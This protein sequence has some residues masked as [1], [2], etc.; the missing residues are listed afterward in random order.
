MQSVESYL[1]A[2][3]EQITPLPPAQLPLEQC[4]G[5]TLAENITAR[6]AVPRFDN[7][8]MDGFALRVADLAEASPTSPVTLPVSGD[9]A[10]GD[11]AAPLEPGTCQRI[12]TGA[13]IP[14][15]ADA[16]V[17]VE[18]TNIPAGPVALPTEVVFQKPAKLGANIR[19]AAEDVAVGATVL[20]AGTVLNANTLASAAS[21]G[22]GKL[23]VRPRVRVAVVVSGEELVAP[24]AI[25][26]P[27]QIPD[28]N[29]ILVSGLVA[30]AGGELVGT[31]RTGDNPAEFPAIF[32]QAAA[33][34][35]LVITTGGVSAGAFDVVKEVLSA[36]GVRFTK[37]KMKPGKPQ[38][39]GVIPRPG[40]NLDAAASEVDIPTEVA[41]NLAGRNPENQTAPNSTKSTNTDSTSCAR[42]SGVPRGQ[43]H[44]VVVATLPGNPVSVFVSFQLFVRAAMRALQ[45]DTEWQPRTLVA[46]AQS[47]CLTSQARR[48]YVPARLDF[49]DAAAAVTKANLSAALPLAIPTHRL[50]S[51]S[52][53][54]ATL[55]LAN[56][57]IVVP[58]AQCQVDGGELVEVVTW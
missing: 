57:L 44:T 47:S 30:E 14:E 51:G 8:A 45:G 31:W 15:G 53:L 2:C 58:E 25:P 32:D 41:G 42:N 4:L 10:A 19:R 49:P 23:L 50:G 24:G 36:R 18:D 43:L 48:Q 9:V 29:T 37:V 6:L 38:G 34:A 46:R 55:A 54:V 52:H 22:Y 33:H 11:M 35:D 17:M 26:D 27:G 1:Q 39:F 13:P 12:M 7:S 16:V 40:L 3:L 56:A 21:V 20:P 28:S 5:A